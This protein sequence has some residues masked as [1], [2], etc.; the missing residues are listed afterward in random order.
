VAGFAVG[1]PA[2]VLPAGAGPVVAAV[3]VVAVAAPRTLR[4]NRP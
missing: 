4:R 1:L 2:S 3:L